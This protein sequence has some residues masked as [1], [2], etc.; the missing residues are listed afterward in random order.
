M[1]ET[2]EVIGLV[3]LCAV[4]VVLLLGALAYTIDSI[5]GGHD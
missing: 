5:L 2:M 3:L 1:V 4:G